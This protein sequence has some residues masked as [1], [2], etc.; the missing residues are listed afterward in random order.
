MAVE[1]LVLLSDDRSIVGT[2]NFAVSPRAGEEITVPWPDDE[3]GVRIFDVDAVSHRAS[4]VQFTENF[5]SG[6]IVL[7]VT[8]IN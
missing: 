1:A 4:G 6:N 3:Y 2:F 5:P 8:E 7:H